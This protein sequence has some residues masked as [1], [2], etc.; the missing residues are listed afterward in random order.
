MAILATTAFDYKPLDA[1]REIRLL[2]VQTL[3]VGAAEGE[4]SDGQLITSTLLHASL[5]SCPPYMALSYVWG[6][7]KTRLP[8]SVNGSVVSITQNLHEALSSLRKSEMGMG[9]EVLTLWVDALCINQSDD[10]EKAA[11]VQLMRRIYR[12]AMRVIIWLGPENG[13]ST[14]AIHQLR[15]IGARFQKLK[16]SPIYGL[17]IPSFLQDIAAK[18][19]PELRSVWHLFRGRP[20][21]R[22]VWVI[23]EAVLARHATV[24][25][26]RYSI[27][28]NIL[29]QALRA[30]H[31]AQSLRRAEAAET[32]ALLIIADV[33]QDIAHFRVCAEKFQESGG[34]GMGLMEMLWWTLKAEIQATDPRDRVYG[35]LG[36]VEEGDRVRIPVDYS[37]ATTLDNVLFTVTRALLQKHG[38]EILCYCTP[39]LLSE[40]LPS[41]VVN[42]TA[43]KKVRLWTTRIGGAWTG[44]R[45]FAASKESRWDDSPVSSVSL[46]EPALRLTGV[47]VDTVSNT[48]S[49]F[50]TSSQ[51][52]DYIQACRSW[53]LEVERLLSDAVLDPGV[54]KDRLANLWRLPIAD[55]RLDG[56][57]AELDDLG[58]HHYG[59]LIGTISHETVPTKQ[60][61]DKMK[62]ENERVLNET[63][64]YRRRWYLYERRPFVT[65]DGRPGL[66]L[67]DTR[68][69][70]QI[71][72]LN[73]ASVPFVIRPNSKG[74]FR[75]VG[76]A[77]IYGLMDGEALERDAS[78][79]SILLV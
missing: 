29:L 8:I 72:V 4:K 38:P 20:Y 59:L 28:W 68:P 3:A 5:D 6:D 76:E 43:Q 33:N 69:G 27:D 19:G 12:E 7:A 22:R 73:G 78:L 34:Q 46:E 10:A 35:L 31:L 42:W 58:P 70:D 44:Y 30:L 48:G 62:K 23:Q 16:Q 15:D 50:N 40:S 71:C 53:F 65:G 21:W 52:S 39:S 79:Q 9:E 32:A 1:E 54:R 37:A 66:A 51:A 67:A 74:E 11:Q 57:R 75:L 2:R 36:L 63:Y 61:G 60:E 14:A 56:G 24:W 25:C 41:W 13:E 49:Q 47:I 45:A 77:Y 18:P 17:R 26:G 55:K 64:E